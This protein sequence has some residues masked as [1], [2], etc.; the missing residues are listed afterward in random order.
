LASLSAF[1]AIIA[2]EIRPCPVRH[3]CVC[4]LSYCAC[5]AALARYILLSISILV[6]VDAGVFWD[7]V[8]ICFYASFAE[9]QLIRSLNG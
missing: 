1:A 4:S 9:F 3:Q 7:P 8:D 6:S 2:F 5:S